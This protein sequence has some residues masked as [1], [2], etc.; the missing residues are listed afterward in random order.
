M[1]HA[2]SR[3]N[4][5][6]GLG[7]AAA[8]IGTPARGRGALGTMRV[9]GYVFRAAPEQ[10]ARR[11]GDPGIGGVMVSN[12]RDVAV[13]DADGRWSL[14]AVPGDRIFVIKPAHF[15][16]PIAHGCIPDISRL[17]LADGAGA[18]S[19]DFPLVPTPEPDGFGAILLT[20]TQPDSDEELDFVRDD[21]IAGI[22]ERQAAFGVHHGDVVGDALQLYPR[23]RQLLGTTAMPW[24]HCAGNHDIDR[25][26]V[27]DASSRQTWTATFGPRRYAFHYARAIFFILDNVEYRGRADGTY[28]GMLGS[29]QL[30]FVRNVLAHVP[31]DRL[32]VLSMHIPLR[33]HL[34]PGNPADT[35]ADYAALLA[36]L[37]GRPHTVSFA[38]HLHATEHHYLGL[39]GQAKG[40]HHHHH[41]LTAGSGSWWSGPRD[42]RGIPCADSTDG[43]PNGFHLLHVDG[44]RY[45]TEF[46]TAVGER[47]AKCRVAVE[48]QEG[49]ADRSQLLVNVFD[50][51]PRTRVMCRFADGD[52]MAMDAVN[53]RDPMMCRLFCGDI[54]RKSWVEATPSSHI[55]AGPVPSHVAAGAHRVAVRVIDEYGRP[56]EA[57]SLVEIRG[58]RQ[59]T[60]RG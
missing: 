30:A 47:Q 10:R 24:H 8:G 14:A 57:T 19:I 49:S 18:G 45:T 6:A 31:A 21:I 52:W 40:W 32:V 39:P 48:R 34:D 7:A 42:H 51:G 3:R 2:L 33:C 56:H 4:V 17:C 59:V 37:Q 58:D 25:S 55:W 26:A 23:Y 41:V 1:S 13:S 27:D 38:G 20:D 36:L 53:M 29:E 35:T 11:A 5:L 44:H 60:A 54:P 12:G 16:V 50:G 28:R 15:S 22:L 46:I 9:G 43:T